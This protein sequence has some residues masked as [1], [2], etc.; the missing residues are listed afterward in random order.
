MD[1]AASEFHKNGKYDLD[2]KNDE[3]KEEDWIS[4]DQLL[5][6]YQ[7]NTFVIKSL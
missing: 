7:G 2:F 4:S 5:E 6:M 3:S 1:V